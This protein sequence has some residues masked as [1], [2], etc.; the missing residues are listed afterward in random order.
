MIGATRAFSPDRLP[1]QGYWTHQRPPERI[2][3]FARLIPV[4]P[5]EI[6]GK[7][8]RRRAGV[9]DGEFYALISSVSSYFLLCEDEGRYSLLRRGRAYVG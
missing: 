3:R 5:K 1:L 9:S 8:L 7:E 6:E 2:V 4:Y